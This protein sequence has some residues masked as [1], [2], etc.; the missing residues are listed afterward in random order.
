MQI[1]QYVVRGGGWTC[2]K[3]WLWPGKDR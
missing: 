1:N 2:R 3:S